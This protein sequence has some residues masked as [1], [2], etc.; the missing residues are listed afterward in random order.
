MKYIN[1]FCFN[2]SQSSEKL[3]NNIDYFA[4]LNNKSTSLIFIINFCSLLSQI[5][6]VCFMNYFMLEKER[7]KSKARYPLAQSFVLMENGVK[8]NG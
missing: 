3:T 2:D 5:R 4:S 6:K 7:E 8:Q 1:L